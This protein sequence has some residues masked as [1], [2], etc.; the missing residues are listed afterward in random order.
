ML[1]FIIPIRIATVLPTWLTLKLFLLV[2]C[3]NQHLL[4]R[5]PYDVSEQF[6][7]DVEWLTLPLPSQDHHSL[8]WGY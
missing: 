2:A 6:E 4:R 7:G 5:F 1:H 3:V 8:F